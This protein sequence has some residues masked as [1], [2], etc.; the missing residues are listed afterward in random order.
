L[1]GVVRSVF[2][3]AAPALGAAAKCP[4][5]LGRWLPA[6]AHTI[7]LARRHAR[8]CPHLSLAKAAQ[9]FPRPHPPNGVS[10]CTAP[11][12]PGIAH[13][14]MPAAL[15]P[16]LVHMERAGHE[17]Q[18]A[19]MAR[20]LSPSCR[21]SWRG[22]PSPARLMPG[23]GLSP[24]NPQATK[25]MARNRFQAV[26]VFFIRRAGRAASFDMEFAGIPGRS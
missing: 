5:G 11:V 10:R 22:K 23:A 1:R 24:Q 3:Y 4:S 20:T 9:A 13:R 6:F 21:E 26:H 25:K 8:A 2:F 15:L 18:H 19:R 17:R 16:G 12:A 14:Q 7:T